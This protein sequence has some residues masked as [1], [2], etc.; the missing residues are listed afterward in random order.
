MNTIVAEEILTIEKLQ[1][2]FED[3]PALKPN[4]IGVEAGLGTGYLNKVLKEEKAFSKHVI[5]KVLPVI[6]KYGY[7]K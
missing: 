6:E 1:K 5:E 3:R 2:F 4:A 7:K